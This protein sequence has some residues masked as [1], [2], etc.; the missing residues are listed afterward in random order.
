LIT[1]IP[2]LA[3]LLLPVELRAQQS[4]IP[5]DNGGTAY[6]MVTG[7]G[8]I[9]DTDEVN[10]VFYQIPATVTGPIYFAIYDGGDDTINEAVGDEEDDSGGTGDTVF[11]LL[12]GTGALTGPE[13][14]TISFTDAEKTAGAP[15]GGIT[16][17]GNSGSEG[18][19]L[20]VLTETGDATVGLQEGAWDY[21]P[22]VSPGDGER[23]GNSY[24]FRIVVVADDAVQKN[25]Y[26]LDVSGSDN[27]TG[28]PTFVS[29]AR[30]FAYTWTLGINDSGTTYQLYPFVPEGTTGNVETYTFDFE[31]Q[32]QDPTGNSEL[33]AFDPATDTINGTAEDTSVNL[34][35]QGSSLIYDNLDTTSGE[36]LIERDGS[37]IS[38]T[39]PE[40]NGTWLYELTE[41]FD[42]VDPNPGEVWF[43]QGATAGAG[44]NTLPTIFRT[45]SDQY[46]PEEPDHVSVTADDLVVRTDGSDNEVLYL[47][48]VDAAGEA[49]PYVRSID[50][51]LNNGVD[52][53][54]GDD[55]ALISASSD[56]GASIAV[57]GQ[58][59]TVSTNVDGL[60]T[61]TLE[62][63]NN[64]AGDVSVNLITNGS[65]GSSNLT[66]SSTNDNPTLRVRA[67]TPPTMS[68]GDDQNIDFNTGGAADLG[69]EET[70][71][72]TEVESNTIS[73]ALD[74]RIKLPPELNLGFDG[75]APTVGGTA[76][77]KVATTS[78]ET[79]GESLA[80]DDVLVLDIDTQLV[81]GET[82]TLSGLGL[83]NTG[84]TGSGQLTLS[85]DGGATY[86]VTD[87]ENLFVVD[88]GANIWYGNVDT[89][90]E[91][92]N[93][94]SRGSVPANGENVVIRDAQQ[95][96]VLS[97]AVPATGTLAHLRIEPGATVDLAG[98]ALSVTTVENRGTIFAQGGETVTINGNTGN[99]INSFDVDSGRVDY[100]A[101]YTG[102]LAFG[103]DYFNLN[104]SSGT[105]LQPNANLNVYN[106]LRVPG[107]LDAGAAAID[108]TIGGD[109]VEPG[110]GTF[111]P[112]PT[113]TLEDPGGGATG[114][115]V[116]IDPGTG[117]T[118][119]S[120]V[121]ND[122]AG[123]AVYTLLGTLTTNADLTLASGTL[124]L[125]GTSPSIGGNVTIQAAGSIDDAAGTPGTLRVDGNWTNNAGA[126]GYVAQGT[127]RFLDNAVTSV[128][129][130][131]TTFFNFSVPNT[132]GAKTIEFTAG[133]R[134]SLA[135][136][137]SFSVT[138]SAGNLVVLQSTVAGT[139]WQL[140]VQ[141]GS[142]TV[143]YADI[144]DGD[145]IGGDPAGSISPTN[146]VDSGGND[147]N[148]A[149]G[150]T[151]DDPDDD[152][153]YWVFP[154]TNYSWD[155]GGA[156]TDWGTAANWNPDG[157]PGTTDNATI[158]NGS[159]YV[160]DLAADRSVG[161]LTTGGDATVRF[162]GFDFSITGTLTNEGTLRF[163]TDELFSIQGNSPPLP[164]DFDTTSGL[165]LA[166][167][168][169]GN[170]LLQP[171]L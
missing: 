49:V 103:T 57:G 21:F 11:R 16:T 58:S 15:Y 32:V 132:V 111:T 124:D 74:L 80:N 155:N 9:G 67:G 113:V 169:G 29:G 102:A 100:T 121:I 30:A 157:V 27:G 18:T 4:R 8:N 151:F 77:G 33:F 7:D 14:K 92:P 146:S 106:E 153:A 162:N 170:E 126:G 6:L 51:S 159:G 115:G 152:G 160:V 79:S 26:R 56:T 50:V 66:N 141:A 91:T 143:D 166:I 164:A 62:G 10:V 28:A 109:F 93:N 48:L 45:Y 46:F 147:R 167:P 20:G 72:I 65:G 23:V 134:Q 68:S 101:G 19:L 35:G 138:G 90:W 17:V 47:Q 52:D 81:A 78:F 163:R 112:G 97:A 36:D 140:D 125:N 129:A 39:T 137:G 3:S 64:G 142:S 94:W 156:G 38:G 108:I 41:F 118:F 114:G 61:I 2:L 119:N 44:V 42:D 83:Q 13:A 88:S 25:G 5:R 98:N 168:A 127:V 139:Q 71:T 96:P 120:V 136:G 130:G 148:N 37:A 131:D 158:P 73:T 70:I 128:I 87:P 76:S 161:T 69:L 150:V 165:V 84:E 31:A 63:N 149:L 22:P 95:Q 55:Y 154:V 89:D 1:W 86:P 122:G 60:V 59:A 135:A 133:S 85:Y 116:T 43:G 75:T 107:V 34:A 12:G 110:T 54:G 40:V 105:A 123:G 145:L 99:A 104:V 53:G 117:A 24:V 144:S 82:V 171:H